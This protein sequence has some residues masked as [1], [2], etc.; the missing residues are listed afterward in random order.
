MSK[1]TGAP[2]LIS[3]PPCFDTNE[4]KWGRP[5]NEAVVL[6]VHHTSKITIGWKCTVMKASCYSKKKQQHCSLDVKQKI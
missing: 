5:G 2:S 1:L 3:R 4:Y 6:M